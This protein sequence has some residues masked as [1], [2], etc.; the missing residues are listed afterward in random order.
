MVSWGMY[1]SKHKDQYIYVSVFD[2]SLIKTDDTRYYRLQLRENTLCH[3]MAC[4]EWNLHNQ[5]FSGDSVQN[6]TFCGNQVVDTT[7]FVP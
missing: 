2:L 5:I 1:S 3:T 7:F 6:T 4:F